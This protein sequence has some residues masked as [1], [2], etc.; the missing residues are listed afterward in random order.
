MASQAS[1]NRSHVRTYGHTAAV[2]SPTAAPIPAGPRAG[3]QYTCD[4]L[5]TTPVRRQNDGAGP[6]AEAEAEA[7]TLDQRRRCQAW[8]DGQ[9]SFLSPQGC[10]GAGP[11]TRSPDAEAARA[12]PGNFRTEAMSTLSVKLAEDGLSILF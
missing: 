12:S 4:Q 11:W 9:S 1:E 2:L 7:D 6:R 8:A 3:A 5:L 10:P